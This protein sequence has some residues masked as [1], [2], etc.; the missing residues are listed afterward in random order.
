MFVFAIAPR[1]QGAWRGSSGLAKAPNSAG[2]IF[3]ACYARRYGAGRL[4]HSGESPHNYA[5]FA[6]SGPSVH[7]KTR[8]GIMA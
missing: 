4:A 2:F 3:A 6:G 5:A 7:F 8:S 1:L